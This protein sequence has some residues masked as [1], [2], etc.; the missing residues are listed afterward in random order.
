MSLYRCPHCRKVDWE[1]SPKLKE[2]WDWI[3]ENYSL[4]ITS[5]CLADDLAISIANAC[6]KLTALEK[7]GL[8]VS[9]LR[10]LDGGGLERVYE[11]VL[12]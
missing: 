4:E 11:L 5:R 7:E 2:T 3:Q 8:I 12:F 1:R 9:T 10:N 6:N